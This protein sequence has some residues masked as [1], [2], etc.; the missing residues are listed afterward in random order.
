MR[1]RLGGVEPFDTVQPADNELRRV[2]R[3]RPYGAG[4]GLLPVGE[5]RVGETVGPADVVPVVDV[6]RQRNHLRVSG[7]GREVFV[8]RRAGRTALRGEEFH[9]DL[10]ARF[11]RGGAGEKQ[12]ADGADQLSHL[13]FPGPLIPPAGYRKAGATPPIKV[14]RGC[15]TAAAVPSPPRHPARNALREGAGFLAYNCIQ[16][17]QPRR[18]A[19]ARPHATA[20]SEGAER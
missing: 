4:I 20:F 17:P 18:N 5:T 2:D 1:R 3:P 19:R 7:Q 15:R 13:R 8:R 9:H 11:G 12:A 6:Q 10:G 14:L 16:I